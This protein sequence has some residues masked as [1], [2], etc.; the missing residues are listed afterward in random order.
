MIIENPKKYQGLTYNKWL[1]NKSKVPH[2]EQIRDIFDDVLDTQPKPIEAFFDAH[3]QR[4]IEIKNRSSENPYLRL[5]DESCGQK[6]FVRMDTLGELY[7]SI[8]IAVLIKCQNYQ[9]R[10][11]CKNTVTSYVDRTDNAGKISSNALKQ[12]TIYIFQ[13]VRKRD[14]HI[15]RSV[16]VIQNVIPAQ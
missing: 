16:S 15:S 14:A 6:K 11:R 9:N 1:D 3:E 5:T 7:S 10:K 2:R 4:G 8:I 13:L 12:I